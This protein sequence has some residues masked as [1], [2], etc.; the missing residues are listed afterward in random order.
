MA[1]QSHSKHDEGGM[2]DLVISRRRLLTR[3]AG[4]SAAGA[5]LPLLAACGP[6]APAVTAP[7]QPPQAKPAGT[8]APAAQAAAEL[9]KGGSL[10]VATLGEPPALDIMLCTVEFAIMFTGMCT[11][12]FAIMR[13]PVEFIFV[14]PSPMPRSEFAKMCTSVD[15]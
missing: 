1:G 2:L 4:M 9:N 13:E 11:V 6:S 15:L 3:V 5:V 12:E 14:K 10:K 8:S 7:T